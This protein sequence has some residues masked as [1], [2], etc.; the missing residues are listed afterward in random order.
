MENIQF[1]IDGN[2]NEVNIL[3]QIFRYLR[4]WYWFLISMLVCFFIVKNYLS[5]T[6]AIYE[7]KANIKIIDDSKNNF[8][9][10]TSGITTFSKTRVNLDNQIEVLKSNR[11]L[12]QVAKNLSLNTQYFNVGYLNNIE[13]KGKTLLISVPLKEVILYPFLTISISIA[14]DF[15]SMSRLEL[16]HS[17]LKGLFFHIS[18]LF[19]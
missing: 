7:S 16:N 8:V 14:K 13:L 1:E 5:H 18:I 6:I 12:E 19:K 10:P 4:Y 15:V 17:T 9:L 11:L 2:H 3:D